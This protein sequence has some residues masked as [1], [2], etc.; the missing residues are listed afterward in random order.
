MSFSDGSVIMVCQK[1]ETLN[2]RP[3]THY[4]DYLH[5]KLNGGGRISDKLYFPMPL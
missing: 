2:E 4:T 1:P 5:A 3:M